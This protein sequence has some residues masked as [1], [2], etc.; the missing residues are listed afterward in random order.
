[1]REIVIGSDDAGS[2]KQDAKDAGCEK[3]DPA[4]AAV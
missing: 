1:M 2:E 4:Y 3:Q